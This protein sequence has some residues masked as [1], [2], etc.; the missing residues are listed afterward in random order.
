[1]IQLRPYQQAAVDMLLARSDK[2]LLCAHEMGAGKTYM[3]LHLLQQLNPDSAVIIAPAIVRPMWFD[4][5]KEH[6]PGKNIGV[7]RK[8]RGV[9]GETKVDKAAHEAPWR[10]CSYDL[11]GSLAGPVDFIV[12]DEAH[13]LRNPNSQ[14]S[15]NVRAIFKASPHAAAVGLSGTYIP[16]EA[17]Q[18]WNPI[19]TFFP[20]AKEFG[21]PTKTNDVAWSFKERFCE[22]EMRHGH[23][24]YHGLRK[25]AG[26]GLRALLAPYIHRVVQAEFAHY[27]PPLFVEPLRSDLPRKDVPKKWLANVQESGVKHV[28]I[29]T[30]HRELASTFSREFKGTL[31]TGEMSPEKRAA[32]LDACRNA[33][34]SLLVGTIDSLS[35]G[36]SLSHIKA[37][38]VAEWT[39]EMSTMAQFIG[40]FARS[41]SA[42]GSPTRVEIYVSP[43]DTDKMER[44]RSRIDAA[45]AVLTPGRSEN[46]M[47]GAFADRRIS[48]EEFQRMTAEVLVGLEKR[49]ATRG[50]IEEDDDE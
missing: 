48:D 12:C 31:I 47:N 41:D 43:N 9:S 10:V 7:I 21:Q 3:A 49:A 27:L 23:P 1:M 25:E 17:Y 2:R 28:G 4:L 19:K 13:A 29:F 40:R 5:L 42:S 38:L 8:G 6:C 37:A 24:H 18:I 34:S 45:N 46:L 11:A 15:Q 39:T 22:L 33:P 50:L 32:L 35:E 36:I 14:Q 30:H 16:N 26:E 44:L 20:G